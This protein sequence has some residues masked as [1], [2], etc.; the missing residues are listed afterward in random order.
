MIKWVW[1]MKWKDFSEGDY[2]L[3]QW[4]TLSETSGSTVKRIIYYM[5]CLTLRTENFC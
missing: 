4:N 3:F 2:S 1:I 5:I